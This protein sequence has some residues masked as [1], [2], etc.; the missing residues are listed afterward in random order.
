MW[1][2]ISGLHVQSL[3]GLPPMNDVAYLYGYLNICQQQMEGEIR[4]DGIVNCEDIEALMQLF[5]EDVDS[6]LNNLLN[7]LSFDV[8]TKQ[9]HKV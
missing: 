9:I 7:M 2:I 1:F 5:Q 3:F 6:K 4:L 8:T